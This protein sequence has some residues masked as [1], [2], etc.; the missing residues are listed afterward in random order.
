MDFCVI[1][2]LTEEVRL[3][4]YV[5]LTFHLFD[6]VFSFYNA[7]VFSCIEF[8]VKIMNIVFMQFRALLIRVVLSVQHATGIL[9]IVKGTTDT[10]H[11][12]N[13]FSMSDS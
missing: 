2:P 8:N 7:H 12:P 3:V 4:K 1:F 6:R 10:Y 13:L 9:L 5:V 11:L